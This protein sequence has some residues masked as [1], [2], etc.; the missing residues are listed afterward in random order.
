MKTMTV[1]TEKTV[2]EW[3]LENPSATRVFEK[4]G[5]DYCCGGNRSLGEA[6]RTANVKIDQVLESLETAGQAALAS[7][8]ERDWQSEP[9]AALIAHS[10]HPHH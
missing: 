5:I 9:I 7:R 8:E 6:C 4:L 3:A 1:T 10:Q 2:R